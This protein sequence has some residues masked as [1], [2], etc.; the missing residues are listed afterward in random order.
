MDPGWEEGVVKQYPLFSLLLTDGRRT[1]G[2]R[3]KVK[4]LAKI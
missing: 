3:N 2:R 4:T 1:K